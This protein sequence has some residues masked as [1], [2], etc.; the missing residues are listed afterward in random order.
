MLN[1]GF[2]FFETH[3]LYAA[4]TPLKELRVWKGESDNLELGLAEDLYVTVPHGHYRSLQ[5]SL[6]VDEMIIAPV[7][8][9]QR[10]GDLSITIGAEPIVERPLIALR[11]VAEGG[12]WRKIRDSVLLLFR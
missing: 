11:Q 9:G 10:L 5:A 8:P 3:R 12:L 4:N 1:Y 6:S 2:R 7:V